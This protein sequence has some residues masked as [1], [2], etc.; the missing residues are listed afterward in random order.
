MSQL[1]LFYYDGS[2]AAN[3]TVSLDADT[4]R[5]IWQ[6]L[7]MV[8]GDQ[9]LLTDG[10]GTLATCTLNN[11]ERQTCRVTITKSELHTR[12]G[13]QLHLCVAFTKNNSRNEWL[14]EKAT[15]LGVASIVP[16]IVS[17]SEKNHIRTDRWKKILQS[18]MVQSRQYYLPQLFEPTK[19]E[20]AAEMFKKT[21]HKLIAHCI[22]DQPKS[23]LS[24]ML[25]T[26]SETVILI[27]P[28]GDFS[29][30]EVT[31]CLAHGF[32]PVSLGNHRLRTETAAITAAALFNVMNDEAI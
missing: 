2:L 4:G 19:L 17:R 16:L 21:A 22:D 30:N 29:P 23:P 1:P 24:K 25:N 10:K 5:H 12:N 6:V 26:S 9:V 15:E 8:A 28:E 7:R 14:L 11:S 32:K 3:S 13:G 27:G 18:A 31:L 20:A